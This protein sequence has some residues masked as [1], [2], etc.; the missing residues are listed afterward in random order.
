MYQ[1]ELKTPQVELRKV[2]S[3]APRIYMETRQNN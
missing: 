2:I 3:M 1:R